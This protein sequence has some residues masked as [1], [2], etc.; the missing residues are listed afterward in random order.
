MTEWT[1]HSVYYHLKTTINYRVINICLYWHSL[2]V[3]V[4]KDL[5]L[6]T[7]RKACWEAEFLARS[8]LLQTDPI[9]FSQEV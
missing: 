7:L 3:T 4:Y 1:P 6:Q 5:I 9:R 2:R 8:L